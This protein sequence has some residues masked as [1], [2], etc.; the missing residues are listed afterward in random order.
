MN[1][2]FV[3]FQSTASNLIPGDPTW[4]GHIFVHDRGTD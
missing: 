2:R 4:V 1:R 3:A